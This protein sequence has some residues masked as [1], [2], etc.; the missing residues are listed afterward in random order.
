[1]SDELALGQRAGSTATRR[2]AEV[3]AGAAAPGGEA[4]GD[5]PARGRRRARV[6]QPADQRHRLRAA[7]RRGA[8]RAG[9]G[10][11]SGRRSSWRTTCGASPRSPSARR[12]SSATC[13]RSR[14]GRPRRG[15]RR[16]SP[17]W[18][19]RVLSLRAY[20]LRL[21]AIE[22]TTEFEPGLPPVV[23][24]GS[25]L[26]QALLNLMLNAEQAMRGRAATRASASARASTREA[27][28]GR[29]VRHATPGTAS[30][31]SNLSRI[32]DP[33]F[34][35]RDVGEGTGLGLSICYGIV[36]DHGGQ[37]SVESRVQAGHDVLGA[38][39]GAARRTARP[40][41]PILVAHRR[42]GRA[43]LPRGGAGRLGLHGRRHRRAD[44]AL[45]R[46]RAAGAAASCSSI[47]ASSPPICA[48]WRGARGP[49]PADAARAACRWSADD[50]DVDRFGREQARAM[51]DAAISVAGARARRSA[52]LPR[53]TYD[54][55]ATVCSSSSTTSRAFSMWSGRFARRAGFDVVACSSGA[56]GDRPAADAGAPIS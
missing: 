17:T 23:A 49:T 36:R 34:T 33:F 51:L 8:A 27:A 47:A 16:T 45:A 40:S 28:R 12:A 46:Y 56:R 42:P 6:E 35:T 54:G 24:D 4:V 20:E 21:N 3:D 32:F 1:M 39:A 26:Q 41:E 19:A 38:A 31:T 50:G 44:E 30:S 43:R 5:R 11:P 52:R 48:G 53:S 14:G 15:R 55:P 22:L 7:A 37:I 13:W 25:Q 29:A 10:R 2:A 9:R 18:S